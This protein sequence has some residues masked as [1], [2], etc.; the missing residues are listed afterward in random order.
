MR[1]SPR[2]LEA[3]G[4][5]RLILRWS[6]G[7]GQLTLTLNTWAEAGQLVGP[8]PAL[9]RCLRGRLEGKTT[10]NSHPSSKGPG[11][12]GPVVWQ[13]EPLQW[14]YCIHCRGLY[15][16]R[17]SLEGRPPTTIWNPPGHTS[18]LEVLPLPGFWDPHSCPI[19]S[20]NGT[21]SRT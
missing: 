18:P 6:C 1:Q 10:S 15:P 14:P 21:G 8:D 16:S 7:G 4:V 5:R 9:T 17:E 3:V 13:A 20:S 19:K 2:D 12:E 11:T